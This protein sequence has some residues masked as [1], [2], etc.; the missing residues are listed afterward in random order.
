MANVTSDGKV[1]FSPVQRGISL[2]PELN[3]NIL[4]NLELDLQ[5]RFSSSLNPFE[6][7]VPSKNISD[8]YFSLKV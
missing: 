1:Q 3:S 2:N 7:L 8:F 4:L 5:F 6:S